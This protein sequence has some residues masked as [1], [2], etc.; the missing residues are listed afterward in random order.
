MPQKCHERQKIHVF[1]VIYGIVINI[2]IY[3]NSIYRELLKENNKTQ[4]P[5]QDMIT[6]FVSQKFF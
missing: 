4:Q 3:N 1:F 2:H 5:I 6:E